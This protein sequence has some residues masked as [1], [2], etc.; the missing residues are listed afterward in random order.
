MKIFVKNY[1]IKSLHK[2]MKLLDKY[3]ISSEINIQLYSKE[4]IFTVDNNNFLKMN[5][6]DKEIVVVKNYYKSFTLLID[7]SINTYENSNQLPVEHMA[8]TLK[9][10]CFATNNKSKIKLIIEGNND[11]ANSTNMSFSKEY[12][13]VPSNFYFDISDEIDINNDFVKQELNVFLSLLNL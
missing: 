6:I 3:Y 4:G 1:D 9:K 8:F 12:N 7:H 13:M 10:C 5:T 2:F 11:I